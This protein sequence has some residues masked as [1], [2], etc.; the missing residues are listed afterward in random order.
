MFIAISN[1]KYQFFFYASL[2]KCIF[3]VDF[4]Y[5]T[6]MTN[7]NLIIFQIIVLLYSLYN[8]IIV[9]KHRKHDLVTPPLNIFIPRS[10]KLDTEA[11]SNIKTT[12]Y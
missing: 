4:P 6:Q 5:Y 7:N 11:I 8:T 2:T 1:V 12:P 3:S 9:T 10:Q